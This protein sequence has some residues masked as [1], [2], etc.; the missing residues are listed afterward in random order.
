MALTE[1]LTEG[2]L[3]CETKGQISVVP[4]GTPNQHVLLLIIVLR[5]FSFFPPFYNV[6][7]K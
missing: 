4:C 5:S 2:N 1:L 6:L 3:I 7:F